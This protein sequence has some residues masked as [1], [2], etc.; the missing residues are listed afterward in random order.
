VASSLKM[1]AKKALENGDAGGPEGVD[2]QAPDV[3]G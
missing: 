1:L 2:E 3:S